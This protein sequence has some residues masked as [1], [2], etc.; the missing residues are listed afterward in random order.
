MPPCMLM[1]SAIH[2]VCAKHR[3][4]A[5]VLLTLRS[6]RS[7]ITATPRGLW[8]TILV[9]GRH[10]GRSTRAVL[11]LVRK[12]REARRIHCTVRKVQLLRAFLDAAQCADVRAIVE[13]THETRRA[14][15]TQRV[16]NKVQPRYTCHGARTGLE[17]T[18]Q[19]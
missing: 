7:V 9:K 6:G 11:Q 4:D 13:C 15:F 1:L 12:Q 16:A 8:L 14:L 19:Q 3:V 18:V 10:L 2:W 5:S 17:C